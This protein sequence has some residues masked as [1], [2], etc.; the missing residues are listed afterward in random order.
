[1]RENIMNHE[2]LY[3]Q[4]ASRA[5]FCDDAD[6]GWIDTGADKNG[7]NAHSAHLSSREQTHYYFLIHSLSLQIF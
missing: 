2:R 6:V 3:L 1:M 5:V 7:S 4:A